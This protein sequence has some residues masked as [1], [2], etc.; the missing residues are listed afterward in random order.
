M[1]AP[2]DG[3]KEIE[4][5]ARIAADAASEIQKHYF[6]TGFEISYKGE[7]NML[8]QADLESQRVIVETIQNNF[9]SHM[10]LAEENDVGHQSSFDG[11]IW[12]IDPIDGTTNYAHRFPIFSSSIGFIDE[13][14]RQFGLIQLPM[15]K[16]CYTATRGQGAFLNGTPIRVS[17]MDDLQKSLL[18]TGFPYERKSLKENNLDYFNHFEMNSLTV[19]RPGAASYD[20]ACV[21]AGRFDGYWELKLQPWDIAAGMLIVEEAGG[22]ITDLSGKP[23]SN[24]WCGEMLATNGII[25]QRMLDDIAAIRKEKNYL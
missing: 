23:I 20:L 8:T 22:K 10:V 2:M 7:V 16:E 9:P 19:R 4:K 5:V 1:V 18:A 12:V 25:H 21:A 11:P 24:Y 15:L 14:R 3:L 6:R 17:K 13:G